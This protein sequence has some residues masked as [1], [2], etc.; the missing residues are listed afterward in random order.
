MSTL[1]T[2][3][4]IIVDQLDVE[5]YEVKMQ[6]SL[7][8]DLGADSLDLVELTMAIEEQ[9]DL[10]IPDEEAEKIKTVGDIVRYIKSDSTMEEDSVNTSASPSSL[11]EKMNS[12]ENFLMPIEDVFKI[13]GRGTVAIGRIERGQINL[14]DT[15]EIVGLSSKTKHAVVRGIVISR[16]ERDMAMEG[17]EVG[18]LLHGVDSSEIAR[19]QVLATPDSISA[20]KKFIAEIHLFTEEEGGCDEPFFNNDSLQFYF[21]TTEVTGVAMLSEE[22]GVVMPGDN[23]YVYVKLI[24]PIAIEEGTH[25]EVREGGHTIGVGHVI[26]I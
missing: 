1:N 3:R 21:R 12:D 9:F 8:D 13:T 6:S 7:I 15:V 26:E 5:P 11:R 16:E 14:E 24:A 18:L 20:R 19:G 10:E 22:D 17:D 4:K 2:V 25:F 23:S